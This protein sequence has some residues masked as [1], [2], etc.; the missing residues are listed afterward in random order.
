MQAIDSGDP[1]DMALKFVSDVT[2]DETVAT[3]TAT[4]VLFILL[5]KNRLLGQMIVLILQLIILDE[6]TAAS[7]FAHN[8]R[9]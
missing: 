3:T 7:V 6:P 5:I 1:E 9:Q 8:Q 2:G 4:K